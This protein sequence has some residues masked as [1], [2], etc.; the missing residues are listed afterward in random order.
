MQ[1]NLEAPCPFLVNNKCS[2]YEYRPTVCRAFPILK[3]PC[4]GDKNF[5]VDIG[6]CGAFSIDEAK[7]AMKGTLSSKEL[8][9]GKQE[10]IK[11][12][13]EQD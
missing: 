11:K 6:K 7:M 12:Y 3:N 9:M 10:L 13:Y 1:Y 8:K 5:K 2:I 4:F